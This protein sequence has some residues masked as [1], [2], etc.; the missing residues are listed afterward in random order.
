MSRE[1]S[2]GERGFKK[3]LNYFNIGFW[4]LANFLQRLAKGGERVQSGFGERRREYPF[5]RGG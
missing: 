4:G 1:G 2:V 3:G 5:A